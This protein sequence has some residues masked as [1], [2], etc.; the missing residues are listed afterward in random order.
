M[1]GSSRRTSFKE[2][3][4]R[5]A[6][7]APIVMKGM[8]LKIKITFKIKRSQTFERNCIKGLSRLNKRFIINL[9]RTIRSTDHQETV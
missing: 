1:Y 8:Q 5:A 4:L 2:I 6:R 7:E 3:E 9:L